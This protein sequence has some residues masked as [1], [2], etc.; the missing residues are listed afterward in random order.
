MRLRMFSFRGSTF[1]PITAIQIIGIFV[2]C[3]GNFQPNADRNTKGATIQ[4]GWP[5]SFGEWHY[6]G[7]AYAEFTWRDWW[8]VEN[9][10]TCSLS[11]LCLNVGFWLCLS[12]AL[13]G[14]WEWRRLHRHSAWQPSRLDLFLAGCLCSIAAGFIWY[15]YSDWRVE[16]RIVA[17]TGAVTALSHSR[18]ALQATQFDGD[19]DVPAD[20]FWETLHVPRE[21]R[22][23]RSR[24]L[25]LLGYSNG[26]RREL[27][28]SVVG[29]I[30]K[31][32]HLKSL[33]VRNVDLPVD[34]MN[35]FR[36]CSNLEIISFGDCDFHDEHLKMLPALPNLKFVSLSK[37]AVSD[38]GVRELARQPALERLMVYSREFH[39]NR[40]LNF[41]SVSS[42]LRLQRLSIIV[43]SID[44]RSLL[45]ISSLRQLRELSIVCLN[46][47]KLTTPLP[48]APLF[49]L[50]NLRNLLI[51]F[52]DTS[53][54]TGDTFLHAVAE[55]PRLASLTLNASV[56]DQGVIAVEKMT[57]LERLTLRGNQLT[58]ETLE[59]LIHKLLTEV[60]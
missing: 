17:L 18:I 22:P 53:P 25:L 16:R 50:K 34:G 20:W 54:S 15:A 60:I 10:G 32:S 40:P 14:I 39:P 35:D 56:T 58:D 51:E 36:P 37:V 3:G 30:S 12:I 26:A 31:L 47:P 33:V 45:A 23:Y 13:G 42:L 2:N 21:W 44:D 43:S 28:R 38:I 1:A 59:R 11:A 49:K 55:L 4:F 27:P 52:P 46:P 57:R 24:C 8:R 7:P 6:C 19:R 9:I 5:Y 48:F 29:E 41:H